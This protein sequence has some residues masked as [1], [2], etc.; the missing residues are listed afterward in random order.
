[1]SQQ[2]GSANQSPASLACITS[3][4]VN[5]AVGKKEPITSD[6]CALR[7]PTQ[8]K[9]IHVRSRP[10]MATNALLRT[11]S[12]LYRIR[13][14]ATISLSLLPRRPIATNRHTSILP[15][16]Q[17]RR[18][19]GQFLAGCAVATTLW[20]ALWLCLR[21]SKDETAHDTA[22][23]ADLTDQELEQSYGDYAKALKAFFARQWTRTST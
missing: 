18:S 9:K 7:T 5:Q 2:Y 21:S 13:T 23:D 16:Q 20:T 10:S 22:Q 4:Y 12:S 19:N 1:M 3:Y 6:V 15:P 8:R 17:P 11:P 14:C